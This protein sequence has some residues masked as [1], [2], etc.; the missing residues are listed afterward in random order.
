MSAEKGYTIGLIPVFLIL[1]ATTIAPEDGDV[2]A[3]E[4]ADSLAK[5]QAK[6]S[7]QYLP[8]H[9]KFDKVVNKD[10]VVWNNRGE[11]A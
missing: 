8:T 5:E 10:L 9:V 2:N 4:K 1:A 3:E 11:A 7:Q 6:L